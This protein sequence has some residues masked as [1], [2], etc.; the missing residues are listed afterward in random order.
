MK[1]ITL[2]NIECNVSS[3]S[4]KE[5]G[6]LTSNTIQKVALASIAI[7]MLAG[8]VMAPERGMTV[9]S[10]STGSGYPDISILKRNRAAPEKVTRSKLPIKV[11][12]YGFLGRAPYIC[13]PSGFGRTSGCFLR[14]G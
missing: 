13:T 8:C 10:I 11:A 9:S 12:S 7:I 1:K 6:G 4:A 5:C 3:I 2:A 14:R